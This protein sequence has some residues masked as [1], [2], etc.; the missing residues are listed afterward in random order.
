MH[1]AN[2]LAEDNAALM[3]RDFNAP[4][5]AWGYP[6]TT[7]KGRS[8]FEETTDAGYQ[9]LNDPAAYTKQGTSVQRDTIPDLAF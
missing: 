6:K 5:T 2:Q 7:A 3:C 4:H 1:K 8:L 9:L